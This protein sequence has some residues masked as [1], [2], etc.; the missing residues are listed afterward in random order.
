MWQNLPNDING[1]LIFIKHNNIIKMWFKTPK[2]VIIMWKGWQ[3]EATDN[4]TTIGLEKFPI[5]KAINIIGHPSGGQD[6][7]FKRIRK[8]II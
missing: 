8:T 2:L 1:E 4:E 3:N 5:S 7:D 6:M